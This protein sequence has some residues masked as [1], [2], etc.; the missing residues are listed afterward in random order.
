M[1]LDGE[2]SWFGIVR[3]QNGVA[4]HDVA[5]EAGVRFKRVV[6]DNQAAV[7]FSHTHT[8]FRLGLFSSW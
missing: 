8:F 5:S 7:V 3:A 6:A 1:E 2:Q 4:G